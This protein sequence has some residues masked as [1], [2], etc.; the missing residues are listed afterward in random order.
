MREK[1]YIRHVDLM[2]NEDIIGKASTMILMGKTLDPH[3][4]KMTQARNFGPK[5]NK[6]KWLTQNILNLRKKDWPA[7]N[8]LTQAK[9][10][11]HAK[12]FDPRK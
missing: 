7:E 4:K 8:K 3:Q 11:I 10:L 2:S 6:K 1:K 12:K 9:F 5:Q